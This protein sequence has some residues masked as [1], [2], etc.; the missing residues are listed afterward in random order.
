MSKN[1]GVSKGKH[2]P[3]PECNG[4][5]AEFYF[6]YRRAENEVVKNEVNELG[7]EELKQVFTF[8]LGINLYLRICVHYVVAL[9]EKVK[10]VEESRQ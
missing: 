4:P 9:K 3:V 6:F 10:E 7:T 5:S 2:T 1:I 8:I